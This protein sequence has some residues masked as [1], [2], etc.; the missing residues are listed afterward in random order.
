MGNSCCADAPATIAGEE[1]LATVTQ[2][3]AGPSSVD[4][5]EAHTSSDALPALLA[6]SPQQKIK[7]VD[8]ATVAPAAASEEVLSSE[9]AAVVDPPHQEVTS[10]AGLNVAEPSPGCENI[11]PTGEGIVNPVG[12]DDEHRREQAEQARPDLS[13]DWKMARCEGDWEAFLKD[14][15]LSWVLRKAMGASGYGVNKTIH[16]IKVTGERI[17]I[18]TKT[19]AGAYTREFEANGVEQDDEDPLT[20][21]PIK[22][23][24][25]WGELA[26]RMTL[27]L[28]GYTPAAKAGGVIKKQ[29]I[30]RRWM[31]GA[32]MVVEQTAPNGVVVKSYFS[33]MA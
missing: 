24:P 2:Q 1:D 13:G 5:V 17:S 26:G 15:G 25:C 20:K 14:V 28:E 8:E 30:T 6:S 19:A 11:A 4:G 22:I 16:S 9:A 21:K 12:S 27:T 33:K 10:S 29:P 32:S 3:K 7:H 18:E 31:D 23:V